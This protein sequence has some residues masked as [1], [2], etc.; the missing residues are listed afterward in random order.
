M[1]IETGQNIFNVTLNKLGLR[2]RTHRTGGLD[3]KISVYRLP[4]ADGTKDME[5]DYTI[6]AADLKRGDNPIYIC[7]MQE[8]GQMAW[9]S[10]VYWIR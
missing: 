9:S 6:H 4:A 8:D 3:K 7:V 2:G 5:F 10:P 1:S